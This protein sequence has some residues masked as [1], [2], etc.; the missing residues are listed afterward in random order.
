MR[1][2]ASR[3]YILYVVL[4]M[5]LFGSGCSITK[6]VPDDNYLLK[7]NE[8]KVS[9]SDISKQEIKNYVKQKPNKRI[10]GIR[11][12][13]RVYNLSKKDKNNRFNNWLREIGESPVVLDE[14]MKGRTSNQL[15]QLFVNNGYYKVEVKDTSILKK[16]K[17]INIFTIDADQPYFI[18]SKNYFFEDTSISKYIFADTVNSLIKSGQRYQLE[19]LQEERKRL[20]KTLKNEGFYQFTKEYIAFR[21]DSAIGQNKVNILI[22]I[23]APKDV[24]GSITK[25]KRYFINDIKI[26]PNEPLSFETQKIEYLD[27]ADINSLEILYPEKKTMSPKLLSNTNKIQK[28]SIYNLESATQTYSNL[29]SLRMFRFIN[30]NFME[31]DTSINDLYPLNVDVRLVPYKKQKYDVSGEFTNSGGNFGIGGNFDYQR[32][33]IFRGAEILDVNFNMANQWRKSNE[34]YEN[35]ASYGL[36]AQLMFPKLIV[37]FSKKLNRKN[38][39]TKTAVQVG[40]DYQNW[41]FYSG[42]ISNLTYGYNWQSGKYLTHYFNPIDINSVKARNDSILSERYA[43]NNYLLSI[44]NSHFV[45]VTSYSLIY[46]NQ[47]LNNQQ[48]DY[49]FFRINIESAGN[50]LNWYSTLTNAV[51]NEDNKFEVFGLEYAQYVKAD[52]DFRQSFQTSETNNFVYRIFA[53]VGI[54]YKN[55]DV[56]PF[57]RQY[58]SGGANG[59]RAWRIWSLGPGTYYNDSIYNTGDIKLELNL[60]QRFKMFWLLEGAVFLDVGNIWSISKEDDREGARFNI[61]DF[62]KDLAVG[63]GFGFRLDLSFT[64]VRVDVGLKLRDPSIELPEYTDPQDIPYKKPTK[65]VLGNPYLRDGYN[66]FA[67]Q[68][69]LGYPF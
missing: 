26:Y 65:F 1:L 68:I 52:I 44:Y 53:G 12:H 51:P 14:L 19:I 25:H 5:L 36:Q 4:T 62:Y 17:A 6:Y 33:N 69:G 66:Y 39:T 23:N 37:P 61:N 38:Y 10:L 47:Q 15:E 45:G 21:L 22:V 11:F 63:T 41:P 57:E 59:M 16:K 7:R 43:G 67:F 42:T 55:S 60:E 34:G 31:E 50:M 9:E 3:G 56:I 64:L 58:Y 18:N 46:N 35:F 49:T 40:Y 32:K 28:D 30:M 2:G 24:S 13:L 29:S 8:F 48:L 54:P 20:E 27:T